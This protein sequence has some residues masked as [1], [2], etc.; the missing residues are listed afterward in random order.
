MHRFLLIPTHSYSFL[1]IPTLLYRQA[2]C[3]SPSFELRAGSL[4][5]PESPCSFL[6]SMIEPV[7]Q[8][9]VRSLFGLG[10]RVPV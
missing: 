1:L 6:Y 8:V 7:H 4:P 2:T 9:T 3:G 5:A 10:L